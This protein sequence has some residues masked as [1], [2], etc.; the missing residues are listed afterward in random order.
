MGTAYMWKFFSRS[1]NDGAW[2]TP[3]NKPFQHEAIINVKSLNGHH[4]LDVS[5]LY[6]EKQFLLTR[7]NNQDEGLEGHEIGVP[8]DRYVDQVLSSQR[9]V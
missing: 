5:I 7:G 2:S 8:Y 6:T 4:V 9:W 1:E 3:R